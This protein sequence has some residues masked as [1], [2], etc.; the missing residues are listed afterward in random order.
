MW[1]YRTQLCGLCRYGGGEHRR[2]VRWH[3]V[4]LE[5][6][7]PWLRREGTY[8]WVY[9]DTRIVVEILYLDFDSKIFTAHLNKTILSTNSPWDFDGILDTMDLK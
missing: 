3:S 1:L 8:L 4:R 6:Y 2:H 9:W 7:C 5:D